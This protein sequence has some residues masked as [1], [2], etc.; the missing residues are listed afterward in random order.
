MRVELQRVAISDHDQWLKSFDLNKNGVVK[1]WSRER[2]KDY[3]GGSMDH[4]KAHIDNLFNNFCRSHIMS[5]A[6]VRNFYAAKNIDFEE[7]LQ[8]QSKN[9][10]SIILTLEDHKRMI[11]EEADIV[12]RVNATFLER[13]KY[14]TVLGNLKA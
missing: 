9:E 6:H 2:K 14:F 10:Q 5:T 3:G 13:H 1:L 8:S 7:H 12:K 11:D 4:M